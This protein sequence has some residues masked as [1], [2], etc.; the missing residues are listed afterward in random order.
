MLTPRAD[1]THHHRFG[2]LG[3]EAS[4]SVLNGN[5]VTGITKPSTP[6]PLPS[7]Y[8][9]CLI[10]KS[11][12]APYLNNAKRATNVGD[13]VH[14]DTCGPFPTL[15]PKKEAY[16]TIFLD[17]ASNYGVTTLLANKNGAF[18]AWKK[19]EA[20]WELISGN[21]IKSVRLDGAKE[22]TQ[23]SLSNHFLSR[24]ITMQVTAPYAHVQAGKAE[25]YVHTIKDGIQTLLTDAKLP[26]SFWG[27]AALT[28][29]YLRNRLPTSTLPSNT[30]PYEVMH[31]VKPD[32]THLHVWGC[33]CFPSIPLELRT[34][35]SPRRY[36]AIF[37]GYEDNRVGW[38]VRDMAGKYHFS[39][40]V[41]FNENTPGHLSP[42]HRFPIDHALLLPPSVIST[43]S[44]AT[45]T[46][47][48]LSSTLL[49][50]PN[51][52]PS[53]RITDTIAN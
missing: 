22:F 37:V 21:H 26:S 19:V 3:H 43:S 52:L 18:Q 36:E 51:P 14:I 6:Y 29:Q 4:K 28:T 2:H 42:R 40:D 23:G 45:S 9:P 10:G 25:H 13:L 5:Y 31:G 46:S 1:E 38:R 41:V 47:Q 27:D 34:K 35:G 7:R 17:D 48:H 12:Q 39:R 50:T 32:L 8:I 30:T 44:T 33:Q 49:I 15:T 20:S 53:P 11:P 24:G 16:F